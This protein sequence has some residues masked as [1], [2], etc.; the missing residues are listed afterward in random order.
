VRLTGDPDIA[1]D[2]AQEA[3]V[4]L[5]SRPPRDER[6]RAWLFTVATNLV[7]A[8]SNSGR[9]RR[10]L[11]DRA[12]GRAPAADAALDPFAATHQAQLQRAVRS[13]LAEL[14]EKERTI[15]LMREE[16]FSHREIAN[17]V[18]TTTKSVGTMIARA[19]D[20][21]AAQLPLDA[22]DL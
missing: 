1:A 20:K 17:A 8:W 7:R 22:E 15:L 12:A 3:F 5:L 18:G 6:P 9:R 4:R 16:G 21:L 10:A 2:A 19:L 13:A 11:L 14:A